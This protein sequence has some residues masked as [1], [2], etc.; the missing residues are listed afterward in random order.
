MASGVPDDVGHVEKWQPAP[1]MPDGTRLLPL[2]DELPP[3]RGKR[4]RPRRKPRTLYADRGYDP[5]VH[6]RRLRERGITPKI[7]RRGQPHGPGPGQVRWAAESAIAWLHDPRLLRTRRKAR[8]D[9][10]D[11]FLRLAPRMTLARKNP[12]SRKDP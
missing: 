2:I 10:H 9:M 11:A 5:D 8:D 6:R 7:A 4:G 12:A 3:V 1:D